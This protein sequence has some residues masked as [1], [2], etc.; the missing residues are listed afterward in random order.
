MNNMSLEE[1]N[2]RVKKD[3]SYLNFGVHSWVQPLQHPEGHV[4]DVVI[5]GGGQCG[6]GAGFALLRERISNILIIDENHEAL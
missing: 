1:L 4:Y 5:V 3:L 2:E 6:L